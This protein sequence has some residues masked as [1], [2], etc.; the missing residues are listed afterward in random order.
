MTRIITRYFA[1]T[2]AARAARAEL[3]Y[4]RRVSLRLLRLFESAEGL[5]TALAAE[6]VAPETA[7][8]YAAR[9]AGG[10]AV[11]L[12]RAGYRPLGVARTAREV[13]AAQGGVPLDGLVEEVTVGDKPERALSILP[14]HPR[15][16]TGARDPFK[17]DFHMADWPIPLISRRRPNTRSLL[18]R[19][20]RMANWPLPLIWRRAP[21]TETIFPRHARMADRILPLTIRRQPNPER[22]LRRSGP[23]TERFLP[24]ISRRKPYTGSI[25]PRH[26]RMANWPVPHLINGKTGT[27]ALM[28][29]GP[30]MANC[31]IGLLSDRK[32]YTGSIFPRHARMAG[33][34]LPLISRRKPF[35]GSVFPRHARMANIGLPLVFS[36][37]DTSA[38]A[39]F[40]GGSLSRLL[41]IPTLWPRR[42]GADQTGEEGKGR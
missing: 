16:L 18:P 30:R 15:L 21:Y 14:D 34:P 36:S 7:A 33:F 29:G 11:L 5:E 26:A 2:E 38:G 20:A 8:A 41:G 31:P 23:W 27:N 40:A 32:P 3:V 13:M 17:T 9:L 4:R 28:P 19:H 10:G 24:L 25:L 22:V 1:T 6:A 35:S 42:T 39:P 12:V 37:I